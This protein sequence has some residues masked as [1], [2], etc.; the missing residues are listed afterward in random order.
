MTTRDLDQDHEQKQRDTIEKYLREKGF[1]E[2]LNTLQ[3]EC[4]IKDK[5]IV[6]AAV[7]GATK[8]QHILHHSPDD[9]KKHSEQYSKL[10]DF[11]SGSSLDVYK[12]E[13]EQ[14]LFPIFVHCFLE[15][16]GK[17][18]TEEAQIFWR[19]YVSD[20]ELLY[21]PDL[22][23]LQSIKRDTHLKENEKA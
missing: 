2:T 4:S 21:R 6:S 22:R 1:E 18:H 10:R 11:V 14:V 5:A 7:E 23:S 3:Y 15:M 8:N 19:K 20:H 12:M 13:L 16:I 9:P 17:G